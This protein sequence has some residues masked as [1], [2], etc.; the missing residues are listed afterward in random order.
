MDFVRPDH[1]PRHETD[2][3]LPGAWWILPA[4][5]SLQVEGTEKSTSEK[6]G[7]EIHLLADSGAGAN[8]SVRLIQFSPLDMPRNGEAD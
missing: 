5:H 1:G 8:G 2:V 3:A 7:R 4:W 6:T